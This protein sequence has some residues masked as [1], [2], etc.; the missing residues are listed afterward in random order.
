VL[1][2]TTNIPLAAT[3]ACVHL[4]DADNMVV[5]ST[6]K[7]LPVRAERYSPNL[8]V[9]DLVQDSL[10]GR[11]RTEFPWFREH[12]DER[13]GVD[14]QLPFHGARAKVEVQASLEALFDEVRERT[15][16]PQA[17][18][19]LR[20]EVVRAIGRVHFL[21]NK[22]KNSSKAT[23]RQSRGEKGAEVQ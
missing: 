11:E 14:V 7:V 9:G 19:F 21:P 22:Y 16:L 18:V 23:G 17:V 2:N 5:G 10:G 3:S 13:L 12:W 6:C 4:P 15:D 20:Y 1:H 8:G